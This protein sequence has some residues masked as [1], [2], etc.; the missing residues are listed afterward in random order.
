MSDLEERYV[1]KFGET[2]EDYY[3][4]DN[5]A[6]EFLLVS[7]TAK[8]LNEKDKRI[9]ELERGWISVEDRLPDVGVNVLIY[10]ANCPKGLIENKHYSGWYLNLPIKQGAVYKALTGLRWHSTCTPP[11]SCFGFFGDEGVVSH[12]MP[13]PE[14]PKGISDE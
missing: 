9:A 4:F 12:W 2:S 7:Q 5:H 13:L 10:C 14:P 1:D 11:D 3:V 8:A 6:N